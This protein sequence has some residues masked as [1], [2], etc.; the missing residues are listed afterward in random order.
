MIVILHV[1]DIVCLQIRMR[2]CEYD[3]CIDSLSYLQFVPTMNWLW[4]NVLHFFSVFIPQPFSLFRIFAIVHVVLI[5][6]TIAA[7]EMQFQLQIRA[8]QLF[9]NKLEFAFVNSTGSL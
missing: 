4:I 8:N 6:N 9:S 3:T 7:R 5:F 2:W 1:F